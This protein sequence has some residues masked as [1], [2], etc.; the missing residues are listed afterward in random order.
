MSRERPCDLIV[1]SSHGVTGA[2]NCSSDR[3]PSGC[4]RDDQARARYAAGGPGPIRWEDAKRLLHR[5][6]VP[7]DLSPASLDQTKTAAHCRCAGSP[8]D[9]GV[10][11]R[12]DSNPVSREAPPD[13]DSGKSPGGGRGPA[14][15][16]PRDHAATAS[17][18]GAA[19]VR[20]SRGGARETRERPAGRTD[21]RRSARIAPVRTTDGLGHLP[22]RA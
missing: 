16:S 19:R 6:L 15:G 13:W 18:R 9:P 11:D 2:R 8:D 22:H 21:C 5:I 3:P 14:Q 20:R 12:A 7:V 1:M 10:C 4:A 17:P